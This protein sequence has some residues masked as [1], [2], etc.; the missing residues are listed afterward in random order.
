MVEAE[1]INLTPLFP[2]FS[3]ILGLSHKFWCAVFSHAFKS[4][5]FLIL[6]L[7]CILIWGELLYNIVVVLAIH[8]HESATGMLNP[9]PL[10]PHPIPLRCSRALALGA[11]IHA[12]NLH[13]S[14]VLHVVIYMFQCYSPKSS[15]HHLLPQSPKVCSLHLC[16]FCCLPHRVIITIFLNSIGASW[17]LRW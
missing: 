1:T 16:L 3:I 4:K 5:Y 13:W 6:I 8:W 17:W 11:L 7:I 15:H 12:S 9:S 2:P 14:S 10:P